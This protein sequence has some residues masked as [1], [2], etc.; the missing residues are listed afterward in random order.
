MIH[1]D[2]T[3][4]EKMDAFEAAMT[5]AARNGKAVDLAKV[6]SDAGVTRTRTVHETAHYHII[7]RGSSWQGVWTSRF[8]L[9]R[10]DEFKR[11]RVMFHSIHADTAESLIEDLYKAEKNHMHNLKYVG[12][13]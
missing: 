8:S 13:F 11:S 3:T 1:I 6:A 12:G 7:D 4:P 2:L 5:N 10:K 9:Q